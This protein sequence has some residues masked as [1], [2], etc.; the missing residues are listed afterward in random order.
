MTVDDVVA[1]F[2]RIFKV[3]S[4]TAGSFYNGI[5]GATACLK[6]PATCTLAGGVIGNAAAGT[7][8]INLVAP[9]VEFFY[10]LGVPHASIL[11]KNAPA[12]DGGST[13]IP[14]TGAYEIAS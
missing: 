4:P 14:G 11:P 7:V 1:S 2:Q 8:T 13:P 3:S 9:D 6:T 5:V 10:K 12:K